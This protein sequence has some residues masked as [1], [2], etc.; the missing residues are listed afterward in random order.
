M[1]RTLSKYQRQEDP[2]RWVEDALTLA[3]TC[4]DA[5]GLWVGLW[6]PNVIPALGFPGALAGFGELVRGIVAEAP[7]VAPLAEIVAWRAARR[8]LRGRMT[9]EGGVELLSDQRGGWR[10]ALEELT[11]GGVSTHPWPEPVRG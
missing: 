8:R 6:H 3:A 10:I 7:Y 2:A 4:R 9:L 1:D 5:G 11:T